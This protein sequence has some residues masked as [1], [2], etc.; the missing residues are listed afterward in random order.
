[1][2]NGV[3]VIMAVILIIGMVAVGTYVYQNR[4][5]LFK[6]VATITYPDRCVEEYVNEELITPECTVGMQLVDKQKKEGQPGR[7]AKV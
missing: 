4:E 7:S 2:D 1:M 6:R 5:N 3:K